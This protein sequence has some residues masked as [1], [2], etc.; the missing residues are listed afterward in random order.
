MGRLYSVSASVLIISY[1]F[2]ENGYSS[3]VDSRA[4]PELFTQDDHDLLHKRKITRWSKKIAAR[5][6]V[7]FFLFSA[8]RRSGFQGS[9]DVVP[10]SSSR[11]F[12]ERSRRE[13]A[14]Q[15]LQGL[16]KDVQQDQVLPRR[17]VY[18]EDLI[19]IFLT[20]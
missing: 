2:L 12:D 20:S 8:P 15:R 17:K 16:H 3:C 10:S 19:Y 14:L 9:G 1:V 7:I 6:L 18:C 11:R 5:N 13:R 4:G